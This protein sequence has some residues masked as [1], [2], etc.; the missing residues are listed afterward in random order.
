MLYAFCTTKLYYLT[1]RAP[2][3]VASLI[4]ADMTVNFHEE[5]SPQDVV[6]IIATQPLTEGEPWVQLE[7]GQLYVFDHG[8]RV[9]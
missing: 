4:D 2:F 8:E 3:K 1:R 6:T 7:Q 9:R 5:T